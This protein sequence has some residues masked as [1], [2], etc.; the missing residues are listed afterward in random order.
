MDT[1][2][3]WLVDRNYRHFS[4]DTEHESPSDKLVE[5]LQFKQIEIFHILQFKRP[6]TK[7]FSR[8]DLKS[9]FEVDL[10]FESTDWPL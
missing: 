5:R 7:I 9:S 8:R 10:P 1:K 6:E 4:P 3:N 2:F